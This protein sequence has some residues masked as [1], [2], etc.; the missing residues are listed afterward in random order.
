MLIT[1]REKILLKLVF[2]ALLVVLAYGGFFV[3]QKLQQDIVVIPNI[4]DEFKQEL[5]NELATKE[6][7]LLDNPEN[8][9]TILEVGIIS[10]KLGLYSKAQRNFKQA[11][12]INNVDYISYMYLGILYDEMGNY[13]DSNKM[14]RIATQIEPRDPLPFQALINL[15]KQH[16]PGESNEL[17]GIFRAASDYT[18]DSE[19]WIEYA[20]FLEDRGQIRD[21]WIYWQEV[22][23]EDPTN[24][25]AIEQARRLGEVLKNE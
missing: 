1:N 7:F 25:Q 15:Y 24:T 20:Q 12:K 14:L 22:I 18:Q 23:G 9:D 2:V 4:S 16:F 21:A 5:Q 10:Q 8:L 19:I 11:L 17:D 13:D 3:Y 6:A